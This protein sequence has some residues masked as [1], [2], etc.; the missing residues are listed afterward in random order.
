MDECENTIRLVVLL[1]KPIAALA[2]VAWMMQ[3]A[4]KYRFI[5]NDKKHTFSH[6]FFLPFSPL[7]FS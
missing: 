2:L 4:F 3:V 1:L 7:R 5:V 6:P